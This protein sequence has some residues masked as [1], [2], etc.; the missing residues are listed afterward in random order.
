MDE[1]SSHYLDRNNKLKGGAPPGPL[2]HLRG[3]DAAPPVIDG[4]PAAQSRNDSTAGRAMSRKLRSDLGNASSRKL[5]NAVAETNLMHGMNGFVY[6]SMPVVEV[7]KGARVRWYV[8]A[9]GT[10]V[11]LHTPHWHGNN[12]VVNGVREDVLNLL[13]ATQARRRPPVHLV[14]ISLFSLFRMSDLLRAVA[15]AVSSAR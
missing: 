4:T 2:P 14:C 3:S 13:P 12:V 9:L 7:S 5:H 1:N 15:S 8:F 6:G 10:E 11:D